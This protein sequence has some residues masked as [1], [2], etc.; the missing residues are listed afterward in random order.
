MAITREQKEKQL[1]MLIEDLGKSRLTL[2]VNYRGL[3][4]EEMQQ[5]RQNLQEE[6]GNLKVI[7]KTLIKLG[8]AKVPALGAIKDNELEGPVALAFGFT[9]ET[10]P[11]Q[12]VH[13]FAK[14]HPNLEVLAGISAEGK[15]LSAEDVLQ[16]ATLPS[17]QQL[18]AN[19]VGVIVGPARGLVNV[20]AGN[21]RGL[22]QVLNAAATK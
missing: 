22:V 15:L 2:A 18:Q 1:E 13:Q 6:D 9:D 16:L 20:L 4:V 10:S 8:L 3:S 14:T 19:L 11:A 5:L 7:K 17:K 12:V 21:L